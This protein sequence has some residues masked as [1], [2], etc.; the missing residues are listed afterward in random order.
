MDWPI[1]ATTIALQCP[2]WTDALAGSGESLQ[3][4]GR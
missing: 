3:W 4:P 2:I 1:L